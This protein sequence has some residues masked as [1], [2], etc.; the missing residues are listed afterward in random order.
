MSKNYNNQGFTLPELLIALAISSIIMLGIYGAYLMFNNTYYFQRD[1]TDQSTQ[2]RNIIDVI[3]RD[4]KMAGYSIM[5][6]NG[7]N[8]IIAEPIVILSPIDNGTASDLIPSDCGEGISI[9]YDERDVWIG[10]MA[11]NIRKKITY[12]AVFFDTFSPPRCRL[13]RTVSYFAIPFTS[14]PTA[15]LTNPASLTETLSDYIWDLSFET[16]DSRY[17]HL[18]GRKFRENSNSSTNNYV[19]SSCASNISN[20]TPC[21]QTGYNE[22]VSIVDIY[23]ETI[24]PKENPTLQLDPIYGRRFVHDVSTTINLRNVGS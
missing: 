8:S 12:Q 13:Q 16:F 9:E 11:T 4:L 22:N 5:D 24:S 15:A 6:S 17:N 7:A 2:T 3:S 10:G 20:N 14:S 1:L 18:A 19:N 21:T 23:L